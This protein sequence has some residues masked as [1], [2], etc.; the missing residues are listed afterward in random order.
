MKRLILLLL[1]VSV[2]LVVFSSEVLAED[3]GIVGEYVRVDGV[4]KLTMNPDQTYKLSTL[5][6][7]T[8]DRGLYEE[9]ECG[10]IGDSGN[11]MLYTA[12]G[13]NCCV[14]IKKLGSK[15]LVKHIKGW[16]G[17]ICKGGV[18]EKK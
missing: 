16:P 18:Y 8:L 13:L 15:T 11:V 3:G 5:D 6:N 4:H 9:T 1:F 14:L 2:Y 12:G 7:E 17:D 10:R